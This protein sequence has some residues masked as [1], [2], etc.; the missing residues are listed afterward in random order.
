VPQIT[1]PQGITLEYETAGSPGEPAL[2]LVMGYGAQLIAWR[3]PFCER[4]AAAGRFVIS[5][6]NRDCGLS[7]K[8]D[9]QGSDV[10]AVIAAASAGD[11]ERARELAAY[12][13]SDMADDGFALLTALGI[14]RAHVVGASMGGMIAQTMAIEHPE[15]V[16]T[17]TSLMST[18]GEPEFGRST[19]EAR[20]ALLTPPPGDRAGYVEAAER[21][22]LW[23]SK[24]YPDLAGAREVAGESYDRCYHPEGVARQLAAMI[25]SGS[26]AEG[27][28][29][30]QVPTLVIHGLDDTLITP[31]GGERTAELVPG[32]RLLLIEDMGHD[33]PVEL[34]PQLCGA[35]LE[36]TS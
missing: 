3:R 26:R 7:S 1:T 21:L 35:I 36:H 10:A 20:Q 23:R 22:V 32:A 24:K 27:L 30:L 18:T 13:L 34:W 11:F 12:T 29:R 15:R 2:L 19:P 31:S 33:R 4:L 6:D 16:L 5:F 14:E 28:R 25:A 8:L 17:L 9:G